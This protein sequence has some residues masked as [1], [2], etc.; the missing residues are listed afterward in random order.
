MGCSRPPRWAVS[1]CR[2]AREFLQGHRR[3]AVCSL[4]SC[5]VSPTPALSRVWQEKIDG[6]AT[7]SSPKELGP[8]WHDLFLPEIPCNLEARSCL[9]PRPTL[10]EL[11]MLDPAAGPTRSCACQS[12]A[13]GALPMPPAMLWQGW[14]VGLLP[15]R[16]PGG[17]RPHN[18]TAA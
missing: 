7:P 4:L 3:A 8:R 2:Q 5:Q 10:A 11:D 6:F 13:L 16:E 1:D 17:L 12:P 9:C 15:G 14:A 18:G